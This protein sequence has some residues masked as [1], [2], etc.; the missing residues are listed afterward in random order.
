[1]VEMH[2]GDCFTLQIG[3]LRERESCCIKMYECS[4]EEGSVHLF[5]APIPPTIFT[6]EGQLLVVHLF[7]ALCI[8]GGCII[9][10][11]SQNATCADN[12]AFYVRLLMALIQNSKISIGLKTELK[13]VTI[14]LLKHL[15]NAFSNCT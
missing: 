8:S 4:K 14:Q 15:H 10:K 2:T 13:N 9:T 11:L 12:Y 1:M 3:D 6:Q 5:I 7:A